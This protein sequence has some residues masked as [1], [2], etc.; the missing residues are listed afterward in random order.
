MAHPGP[1]TPWRRLVDRAVPVPTGAPPGR[2]A[3]AVAI[4]IATAIAAVTARAW[5]EPDADGGC[6]ESHPVKAKL[7]SG[8]FHVPGGANYERTKPDRCYVDEAAADA[9]GLRPSKV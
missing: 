5:V 2:A 4:A 6:P 8:I 9:D 3:I 1:R 7:S